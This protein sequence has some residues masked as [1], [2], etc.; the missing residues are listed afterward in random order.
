[1]WH[2][3]QRAQKAIVQRVTDAKQIIWLIVTLFLMLGLHAVDRQEIFKPVLGLLK[4]HSTE[5]PA[6][7]Y[8]FF[9]ICLMELREGRTRPLYTALHSL[10]M[11]PYAKR[12]KMPH[13]AVVIYVSGATYLQRT[14][15][16]LCI[17]R[18]GW[19]GRVAPC[20]RCRIV[21]VRSWSIVCVCSYH[22]LQHRDRETWGHAQ[23]HY[24]I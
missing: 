13:F 14:S 22:R 24:I 3:E 4:P 2:L 11:A 18:A 10:W 19:C 12:T 21:E 9:I 5:E 1:M 8:C 20:G 17:S 16:L 23:H 7:Y 15:D 6:M